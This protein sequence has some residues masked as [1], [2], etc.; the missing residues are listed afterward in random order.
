MSIKIM[1]SNV[2]LLSVFI[3]M[4]IVLAIIIYLYAFDSIKSISNKQ[5]RNNVD[6]EIEKELRDGF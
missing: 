6:D 1:F 5:K 3:F 4:M 2:L